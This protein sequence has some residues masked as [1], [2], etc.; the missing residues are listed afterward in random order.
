[1]EIVP[2]G[3][4]T[5]SKTINFAII[6][7]LFSFNLK[8]YVSQPASPKQANFTLKILM[9]KRGTMTT[10]ASEVFATYTTNLDE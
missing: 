8:Q 4:V 3:F 6:S 7:I 9:K 1:M 10:F 2:I 5:V